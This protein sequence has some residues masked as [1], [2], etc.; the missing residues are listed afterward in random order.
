MEAW[1]WIVLIASIIVFAVTAWAAVDAFFNG[2]PG[3]GAGILVGM[4]IGVGWIV[5]VVYLLAVRRPRMAA[6][7]SAGTAPGDR[8]SV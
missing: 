6:G 3:W 5:A 7:G 2:R 8:T 1:V 4:L